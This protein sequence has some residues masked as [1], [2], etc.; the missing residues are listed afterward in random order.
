[1]YRMERVSIKKDHGLYDKLID[2]SL[3]KEPSKRIGWSEFLEIY[4]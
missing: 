3:V 1:M 4:K 2:K